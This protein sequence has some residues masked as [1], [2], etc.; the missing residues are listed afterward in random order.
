MLPAQQFF[1][2]SVEIE[3][4]QYTIVI[5]LKVIIYFKECHCGFSPRAA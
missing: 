3:E 1:K 4:I 2:F 5:R